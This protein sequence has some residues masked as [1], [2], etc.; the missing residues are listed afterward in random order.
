MQSDD[1]EES[2]IAAKSALFIGGSIVGFLTVVVLGLLVIAAYDTNGAPAAAEGPSNVA[3]EA[4]APIGDGSSDE[5][6]ALSTTMETPASVDSEVDLIAMEFSY[7]PSPIVLGTTTK[8]SLH[9]EGAVL[10]NL[11]IEGIDNFVLE[12]EAGAVATADIALNTGEYIVFCS[13][14]GHRE[15]GMETTLTVE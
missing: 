12:A 1:L 4:S 15:A 8:L 11:V 6:G 10:H 3:Q 2:G 5:V 13:I 7:D 14:P 9:N